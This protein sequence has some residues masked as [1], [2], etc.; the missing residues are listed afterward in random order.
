MVERFDDSAGV[1]RINIFGIFLSSLVPA[2]NSLGMA[3]YVLLSFGDG[4][5]GGGE[6]VK[7]GVG[8]WRGAVTGGR[9]EAGDTTV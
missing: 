8:N 3:R 2:V 6:D 9:V 5:R 1:F 4:F 7:G